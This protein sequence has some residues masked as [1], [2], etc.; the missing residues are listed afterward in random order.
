MNGYTFSEI[1]P[2]D[3][4]GMS[5]LD[6]LLEAMDIT[7]DANLD[8]TLGLYD[9]DFRLIATGS[10]YAN[11]LRCLAVARDHQGEGLLAQI[12]SRL[13]EYEIQRGMSHLFLY[14]KSDNLRLFAELG[15]YE[16]AR[17][18]EDVVFMENR[19]GGFSAY[20]ASLESQRKDGACA[21]L[22]MNCNPFTL[23]HRHLVET[24]SRRNDAVHLFLVSEDVSFFPFAD[25]YGLVKAGTED[26][27]NVVIHSTESYM[28]S[29]AVFPSYFMED[30][31]EAIEVQAH[32]DIELF[33]KIASAL[34]VSR[35][36]VG[37][38]PYSR[39]T[40][41]YNDAIMKKLP[42]A[43]IECIVVPR[44]EIAGRPVSASHVRQLI[45]DGRLEDTAP[46]VPPGTYGFFFTERGR[47][48]IQAI[49]ES[50][51][52]VHY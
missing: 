27:R 24:A 50:Q 48:V 45:H 16:I 36:Y 7:R 26:L 49:K 19:R 23:G 38:E 47:S 39:V 18:G 40:A 35:R 41:I 28:I 11:T 6:S 14:T 9:D 5:E 51:S 15:F 46:L 43:G 34:G 42:Q 44:L 37:E 4:R 31:A 21:A 13:T 8:Y 3:R 17:A 22:V 32:L 29:M 52:V 20:L 33:L 30:R 2:S 10:C 1:R 25:R 12:V